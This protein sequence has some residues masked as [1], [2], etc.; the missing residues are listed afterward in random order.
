MAKPNLKDTLEK[1]LLENNLR[2]AAADQE[3]N[4]NSGRQHVM[5]QVENLV[6][7]PY[8]PRRIFPQQELEQLA[9]SI[10]EIGLLEPILVREKNDHY[11]IAA[12]ERRW[13]AH[14]ILGKVSIECLVSEINDADMAILAIAEN[15]DR[16]D[17]SDY[18]IGT[19]L[20]KIETLFPTRKK[21]AEAIGLNRE[22]MYRYFAF[23]ELPEFIRNDLDTNPRLMSRSAANDL[24]R[25]LKQCSEEPSWD[26]CLLEAWSQLVSGD[27][28]QTKLTGYVSRRIKM[29][30]EMQGDEHLKNTHNFLRLGK[31]VGSISWDDRHVIVRIKA[32]IINSSQENQ[33]REFLENL[34]NS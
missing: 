18:E 24:K 17:L 21:L 14:K 32:D 22:D 10:S 9:L 16:E 26:A 15:V 13:R 12:G 1:K 2:H 5:I 11:E 31:K 6:P 19:A 20:K 23:D 28:E 30:K 25:L 8:Q 34:L 7:N 33:L 29:H 3:T 4:F 27:L